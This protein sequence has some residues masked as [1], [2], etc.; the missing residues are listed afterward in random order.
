MNAEIISI[1]DEI[2]IG[3]IVNSNAAWMA[4]ELNKIGIRVDRMVT[5]GDNRKE[6]LSALKESSL[7]ADIIFCTGGLGPTKDDITKS[8][9][10][11]FLKTKLKFDASAYRDVEGYFKKFGKTVNELNRRQAEIPIG[12]VPV[13]NHHGTAPGLLFEKEMKGC[14]RTFIFLPGVPYEMQAM[15]EKYLIP[16]LSGKISQSVNGT[17][18]FHHTLLTQG[19]GESWLSEK[20]AGWEDALPPNIRLAYLPSP[21]MVK[22]R[23]SGKG[24]NLISLKKQVMSQVKLLK[25]IIPGY[26]YGEN[27]DTLESVTGLL[28][29]RKKMT[30]STAESCTGGYIAHLLTSVPG[31][32]GYFKGSV[33]AYSDEIKTRILGVPK[34]VLKKSGAVSEKTVCAMAEGV[35]K[36]YKTDFSIAVTGIAGPSGGTKEKPVGTVWIAIGQAG[37]VEAKKFIFGDSRERFTRITALT[38]LNMLRKTLVTV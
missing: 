16:L 30:L 22:L 10:C 31:A 15:M 37:R 23:L 7:R 28:L 29:G 25:K 14:K 21:G 2:L 12:C 11:T 24:E 20:I 17:A 35:L 18:I 8:T 32:S 6:I 9:I 36:K 34:A 13:R 33:I 4:V 5:V 26:I 27:D 38:A 3:Q 1:G 19:I